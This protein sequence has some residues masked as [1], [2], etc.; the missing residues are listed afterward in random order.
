MENGIGSVPITTLVA[1][2]ALAIFLP[3]TARRLLAYVP[4]EAQ[5]YKPAGYPALTLGSATA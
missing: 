1:V 4:N 5:R 3:I 2:F